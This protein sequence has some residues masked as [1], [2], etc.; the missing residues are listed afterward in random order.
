MQTQALTITAMEG[1]RT[2]NAALQALRAVSGVAEALSSPRADVVTIRFDQERT[3]LQE[4]RAA[5]V[6]AGYET[7]GLNVPVGGEGSCCGS[8][9]G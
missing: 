8:C 1:P 9:G 7:L 2:V 6:A 5:L 3:S 4:V